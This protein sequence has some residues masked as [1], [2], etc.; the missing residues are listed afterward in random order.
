[1]SGGFLSCCKITYKWKD[2]SKKNPKKLHIQLDQDTT[3]NL[4]ISCKYFAFLVQGYLIGCEY[5][6]L[7]ERASPLSYTDQ[8]CF[9]FCPCENDMIIHQARA[10]I[11]ENNPKDVMDKKRS[12]TRLKVKERSEQS[13]Q[14]GI[15]IQTQ[16]NSM[17]QWKDAELKLWKMLAN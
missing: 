11:P 9:F 10:E 6:W 13:E 17:Q 3:G 7:W 14:N 15:S 12:W 16:C 2:S 4:W 8:L 5:H 1:M